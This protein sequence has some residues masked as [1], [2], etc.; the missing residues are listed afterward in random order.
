MTNRSTIAEINLENIARAASLIDPVF[1]NS[2]QFVDDT[3]CAA[4]CRQVLVKVE[5]LNPIRCFKGRGADFLVQ[6]LDRKRTIVCASA[7]NFGQ[8]M[9]YA[10]RRHGIPVQVFVGNDANPVKI[11]R[12]KAMGAT[13]TIAGA[14][15]EAAKAQARHHAAQGTGYIFIEDGHDDAITE[16]AGTIAIELMKVRPLDTLVIPLGD[17]ALITGVAAWV[18]EHS[19]RTRIVGVCAIGSPAMYESWRQGRVISTG[20]THTIADG[21]AVSAPIAKSAERIRKL[22]DDIVLVDDEAMIQAMRLTS[23]ALG[24]LLEPAGAAGLAA[25]RQHNIP[26]D[27]LGTVL[28]GS[29]VNPNLMRSVTLEIPAETR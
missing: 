14:D 7:G 29:N 16:G 2:P 25:I 9:A 18:K 17:G 5:T 12:M 26:G 13:V 8:A 27:S 3:L 20:P 19:P 21:I 23:S 22:V 4:L 28:T 1:L 10:G 6:S 15:F 24:I 11:A